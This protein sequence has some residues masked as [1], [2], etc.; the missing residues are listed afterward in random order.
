MV[1]LWWLP[2]H[3]IILKQLHAFH[4]AECLHLLWMHIKGMCSV[5]ILQIDQFISKWWAQHSS[6][7][8]KKLQQKS[9][10]AS[11][12]A[13]TNSSRCETWSMSKGST[14]ISCGDLWHV[15]FVMLDIAIVCLTVIHWSCIIHIHTWYTALFPAYTDCSKYMLYKGPTAIYGNHLWQPIFSQYTTYILSEGALFPCMLK[16]ALHEF[17]CSRQVF[18]MFIQVFDN[19]AGLSYFSISGK[20]PTLLLCNSFQEI[21]RLL[22]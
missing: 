17:G 10:A 19:R 15:K 3:L 18:Y 1:L 12:R 5:S 2:W 21:W 4:L 22:L 7:R 20:A 16:Q 9:V 8:F 11:K 13:D 14:H 6:H